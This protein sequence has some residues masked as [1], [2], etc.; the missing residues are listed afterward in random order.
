MDSAN[1]KL[2]LSKSQAYVYFCVGLPLVPLCFWLSYQFF[3]NEGS[4]GV[5]LFALFICLFSLALAVKQLT[6]QLVYSEG[7]LTFSSFFTNQHVHLPSLERA[8][9]YTSA[10]KYPH[11]LLELEDDTGSKLTIAPSDYDLKDFEKLAAF[12]HPYIFITRVEKNFMDLNFFVEQGLD[13]PRTKIRHILRGT[14]LYIILP[15]VVL[16]VILI[17]W[18]IV[19]RQPAFR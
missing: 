13:I 17:T 18:A 4:L 2:K 15:C 14:L 1:L 8:E 11:P 9:R 19:T 7:Y 6:G 10:G 12:I 16:T 5:L 3:S